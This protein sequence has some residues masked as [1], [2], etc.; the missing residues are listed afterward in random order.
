M[1]NG[2]NILQEPI[3]ET[4]ID[5]NKDPYV[6]A[7]L[8][9]LEESRAIRGT[10]EPD[11]EKIDS[12]IEEAG[13]VEDPIDNAK[14]T[15]SQVIPLAIHKAMSKTRFPDFWLDC[16]TLNRVQ[17]NVVTSAF[18]DLLEK[19]DLVEVYENK[20]GGMKRAFEVGDSLIK[21]SIDPKTNLPA[22][23]EENFINFYPDPFATSMR[24]ASGE[25]SCRR[26]V[27]LFKYSWDQ[28]V[29]LF[30][31]FDFKN[32]ATVGAIPNVD[33]VNASYTS[34][35][36]SEQSEREV[37][38][39]IGF[40]LDQEVLQMF[41]GGSASPIW[42]KKGRTGDDAY[43]YFTGKGKDKEAFFNLVHLRCVTTNK[44]FSNW[45]FGQLLYK[46]ALVERRNKNAGLTYMDNFTNPKL[47]MTV[48]NISATEW[49]KHSQIADMQI[50][51]GKPGI[52]PI[53]QQ[54]D[55]N[56]GITALR[57]EPITQD[58]EVV[59]NISN[60]DI[61]RWINIDS[62]FTD[63][64]KTLGA[65]EIEE[66]AGDLVLAG[67]VKNNVR[68]IS[69]ALNLIV[70]Y[71]ENDVVPSKTDMEGN[72]VKPGNKTKLRVKNKLRTGEKVVETEDVVTLGVLAEIFQKHDIVVRVAGETGIKASNA[73]IRRRQ[74][75]AINKLAQFNPRSPAIPRM[76][77]ENFSASGLTLS[78]EEAESLIG[79]GEEQVGQ[80]Q[81]QQPNP[82][83]LE[84]LTQPV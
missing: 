3:N 50:A 83:L 74:E 82:A 38:V 56:I 17:L 51:Q 62:T 45:G 57:P 22:F 32:K 19:S 61:I 75:A 69:F 6:V 4:P 63:T 10:Y 72:I 65:L 1:A 37:E 68:E 29:K 59:T 39:A 58:F 67:I 53:Q 71:L 44:G 13:K 80:P 60:K 35:Q 77:Q 70:N 55:Q 54:Q 49:N 47:A 42:L 5:G 12:L 9:L 8:Q 40:D 15:N 33:N 24:T 76:M 34:E 43:P 41:A 52:I 11:I 79:G 2:E 64:T 21:Y 31:E 28:A 18:Y 66:E 78:D 20:S 25:K 27:V 46:P 14:K 7:F 84:S 16:D 30:D 73:L 23:A 81:V 26:G 36:S 48:G